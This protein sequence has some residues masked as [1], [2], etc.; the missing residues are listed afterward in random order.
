ME[1]CKMTLEDLNNINLKDFDDF[2][3]PTVLKDEL[4]SNSSYYITYKY[5]QDIW[6]FAG[7]KFILDETHIMNI[8]TRKDKRNI[9]IGSQLLYA[10]IEQAKQNTSLITL[11]VN[12]QNKTAIHLYEKYGFDKVGKRKKYYDNTY[13]ALIMTKKFN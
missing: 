10:L 8:V 1:I 9:G 3:T 13:D 7:I 5:N 6:G 4:L 12:V 2:W 11:E